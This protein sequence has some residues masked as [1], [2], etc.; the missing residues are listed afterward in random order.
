MGWLVRASQKRNSGRQATPTTNMAAMAGE[1]H[2]HELPCTRASVN[3]SR[4][5][6]AI[7]MPGM[8]MPPSALAPLARRGMTSAAKTIAARP[9]GTFT[10]KIQ[11]QL[12]YVTSRPP[13][14]GP[15][16]A[17]AVPSAP[18]R[19]TA[20]PCSAS[21]KDA[22]HDGQRDREERRAAQALAGAE[23]DQPVDVGREPAEQGE[24]GEG[25]EAE[26]EDALLA[27]L[28]ADT[29]E[30]QERHGE[31]EAVGVQ[32]P[33]GVGE[34]GVEV[35][36][37][38]RHGDVDDGH[39]EQ[40]HEHAD[41]DGDQDPPL[42]RVALLECGGAGGGGGSA[43]ATMLLR[44]RRPTG[45]GGTER[46]NSTTV[47]FLVKPGRVAERPRQ[48]SA[49]RRANGPR[50][51]PAGNAGHGVHWPPRCRRRSI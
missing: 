26:D 2:P 12:P 20:M 34:V 36:D 50:R 39:V 40:G 28:V 33:G 14:V 13:M 7:R 19:P 5:T 24:G 38:A 17:A 31:H 1:V 48:S 35:G 37:D 22:E 44:G 41:R 21:W 3:S 4:P 6:P 46:E 10:K 15:T 49:G 51:R 23:G 9:I 29:A 32:H 18:H 27:V 42:A 30:R 47:E 11:C 43:Q 25:H 8:S 16:A 45:R